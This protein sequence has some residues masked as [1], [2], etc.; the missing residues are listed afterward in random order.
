LADNQEV[1]TQSA[2]ETQKLGE[3]IGADLRTGTVIALYG[4]LGS[5]K[6]TFI[7]G[8]AVGLGIKER[9]LSPT[10]VLMREYEISP[11]RSPFGHL[12]GGEAT[13]ST[14]ARCST[15]YHVDLYRIRDEKDTESLGLQELLSDPTNIIV[16]EW[17]E[18][19]SNMLSKNHIDIYFNYLEENERKITIKVNQ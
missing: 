13:T 4:N 9:I 3:K 16:I 15:L 18:K 2:F 12:G 11:S 19:I 8:L 6:T 7:Q 1:I 5:G 17:P 14:P 10:F